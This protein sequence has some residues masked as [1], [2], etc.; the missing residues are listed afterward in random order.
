[1]VIY[2]ITNKV[3]GKIYI[4]Q[5][6]R[7]PYSRFNE[8]L[9]DSSDDYFHSAIRK[10]GKENFSFDIIDEASSIEELNDKET[11][12]IR[13]YN[14]CVDFEN[15]NGYNCS[16][17]GEDN[18]M[19]NEHSKERHDAIMR[20]ETTRKKIS[21]TMKAKIANGE[22]FTPEHRRNLSEAMR[23]NQH[24]KGH[25]RTAEAIKATAKSLH[26]KVCCVNIDNELVEEFESVIAAAEWWYNNGYLTE[27]KCKNY[28]LLCDVIKLSA[29]QSRYIVGLKWIYK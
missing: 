26:K 8:H 11:Y 23:G 3:N 20:S 1:M 16:L 22:M 12:W 10:Y 5:T 24:F 9:R 13:Y 17:G 27:R 18:P 28:R 25:K 15:C 6:I 14:S 21:D 4:G 7:D 19:F 2:K 29:T